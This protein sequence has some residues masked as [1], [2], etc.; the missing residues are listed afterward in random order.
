MSSP[1][2]IERWSAWF[3][4]G[5]CL[6]ALVLRLAAIDVVGPESDIAGYSE[7]GII[8]RNV[9]EGRGYTFDFYGLRPAH[10]LRAFMP[11]LYVGLVYLALPRR[12]P[13]RCHW[14]RQCSPP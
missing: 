6:L 3:L 8:A 13:W 14:P 4:L 12:R 5:I 7:S 1:S 10:P 2:I 9:V 11:P